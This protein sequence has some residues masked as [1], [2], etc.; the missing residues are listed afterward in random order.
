MRTVSLLAA[1]GLMAV[2]AA[3]AF[4]QDDTA[5]TVR[6]E[7]AP[8]TSGT[9]ITD[10]ITGSE[11]VTYLLPA[12]AEE[13]LTVSLETDNG[14]NTFTITAPGAKSAMF[15]GSDNANRFE[16]P[17]PASGDYAIR[18]FLIPKA[19][20]DGQVANYTI[21]IVSSGVAD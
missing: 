13:I 16:G 11:S 2:A 17:L 5:R 21:T 8:D 20:G 6:V 1:I 14:G 9:S 7:F 3:S 4:G 10:K 18:V 19:A 15:T 12:N